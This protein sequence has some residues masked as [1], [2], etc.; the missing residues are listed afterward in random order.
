MIKDVRLHR[1]QFNAYRLLENKKD[2]YILFGG[3]ARGGKSWLGWFWL[4]SMC[5]AFP[6]TR[7]FVGREEL[8]RL[9]STT[10]QTFFKMCIQ[11]GISQ[12]DHYKYNGQDYYIKFPNGSQIDLLELKYLPRDPL[13]QRFGSSEYTGGW[14]EEAGE[15]HFGAFDVLKTRVGQHLND[16]YNITG[17]ILLTCNPA[18]NWLY[19]TFYIPKKKGTLPE[20][21]HFIQSLFDDNPYRE[22]GTEIQLDSL[23]DESQKQR[24]KFGNWEYDDDPASLVTYSELME[25]K[26]VDSIG[27]LNYCGADI[28]RMGD[29]KS[30]FVKFSGNTLDERI[31]TMSKLDTIQVGKK[32]IEYLYK[33]TISPE[34]CGIDT[35][36]LGAGVY[37]YL[38][39]KGKKCVE[40]ISGAKPTKSAESFEFKNLRSQMWWQFRQDCKNKL[41]KVNSN[42]EELLTDL[43]A[44]RY[45]IV[46]EKVIQVESKD[47]IKQ[48]IGRSPDKGDAVVYAN[49]MRN[50]IIKVNRTSLK[51]RIVNI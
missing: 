23:I 49:A 6:G 11:Y 33:E 30:T 16:K 12:N 14:I 21:Y 22:D 43:C 13:F 34:N 29:D 47:D 27:G 3:G 25:L 17:K 18:K 4:V 9:R 1:K 2:R 46:N 35:V 37:D 36:G 10:L 45:K 40:V 31:E 50:G 28:A 39:E 44:P 26:E 32:L 19:T 51:P 20:G 7:W 38:K 41:I 8:K 48:R 42:D 24:L 15:I 5:M